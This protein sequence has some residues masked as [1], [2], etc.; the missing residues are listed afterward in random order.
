MHIQGRLAI[1]AASPLAGRVKGE[2]GEEIK[3]EEEKEQQIKTQLEDRGKSRGM[4]IYTFIAK[5]LICFILTHLAE[6]N[7]TA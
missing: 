2:S 7:K 3:K 4:V 6:S 1:L 5:I